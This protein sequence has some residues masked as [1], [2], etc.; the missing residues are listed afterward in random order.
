MTL[1]NVIGIPAAI[2]LA[3]CLLLYFGVGMIF[4]SEQSIA[5]EM[6]Q[7]IE[8]NINEIVREELVLALDKGAMQ[9]GFIYIN[10]TGSLESSIKKRIKD[11]LAASYGDNVV[12]PGL[13]TAGSANYVGFFQNSGMLNMNLNKGKSGE[14]VG[15]GSSS[16]GVK[17]S[18]INN[19]YSGTGVDASDFP[20]CTMSNVT[21]PDHLEQMIAPGNENL[22]ED[23]SKIHLD[24]PDDAIVGIYLSLGNDHT[25]S[26]GWTGTSKAYPIV[27]HCN[28]DLKSYIDINGAGESTSTTKNDNRSRAANTAYALNNHMKADSSGDYA[29]TMNS[30]DAAS[31]TYRG[32]LSA[33][34]SAEM[35]NASS[36][37]FNEHY[38][39][40]VGSSN[41]N[42]NK[43]NVGMDILAD[44]GS[45]TP[46]QSGKGI[47]SVQSDG[48]GGTYGG[49]IRNTIT[50]SGG[51]DF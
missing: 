12:I 34:G 40:D 15:P 1:T 32:D 13:N 51:K 48:G 33:G 4:S 21:N 44:G 42:G 18:S 23:F 5:T 35:Q 38:S 30:V 7:S 37:V 9:R 24:S 26:A 43:F 6:S 20:S 39:T 50:N 41:T 10:D 11:Y 28:V 45:A 14:V 17:Y 8:A 49:T 47:S 22:R 25:E 29:G 3:C 16:I 2:V 19:Q 27:L 36:I 31:S 46:T